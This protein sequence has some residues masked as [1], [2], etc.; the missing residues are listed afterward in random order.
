VSLKAPKS[1]GAKG[2][3]VSATASADTG[4]GASVAKVEFFLGNQ[5]LC[6][7]DTAP[8]DCKVVPTGAQVGGQTLRAVVT[9][10]K[11]QTAT[12]KAS[13]K[14]EKFAVAGFPIKVK[15]GQVKKPKPKLVRT[16]S[17]KL[18]LPARVTKAQ[19]C[20]SGTITV[21][22]IRGRSKVL[23]PTQVSLHRD[24]TWKLRFTATVV[25]RS[26]FIATAKF[27]GNAVLKPA[28]SVRRFH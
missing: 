1:I 8:Y 22:V 23:P 11:D 6:T 16:L 19:A 12:D 27:G 17:G 25:A 20:T 10:S 21:M 14:I 26:K 7:D 15:A 28:S 2:A 24:C 18:K 3:T 4:A 13:V 5:S 9:D